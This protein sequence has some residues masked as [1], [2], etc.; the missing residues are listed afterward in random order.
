MLRG[1][2]SGDRAACVDDVAVYSTNQKAWR[3]NVMTSEATV[4]ATRRFPSS[5]NHRPAPR[6]GLSWTLEESD[7]RL[8]EFGG[9]DCSSGE[10]VADLHMYQPAMTSPW[11][12]RPHSIVHEEAE[13]M[14]FVYMGVVHSDGSRTSN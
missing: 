3:T 8:Y 12:G 4:D 11:I 6:V 10:L 1:G 2:L 7:G 14:A 5:A 9:R 13:A